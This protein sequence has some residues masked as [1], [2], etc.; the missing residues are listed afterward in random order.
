L[1]SNNFEEHHCLAQLELLLFP[2]LVGI[3]A[4]AD[5]ETAV[6]AEIAVADE[7]VVAVDTAAAE[8]AAVVDK[9]AVLDVVADDG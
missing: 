3:A 9:L 2:A 4:V 7:F 8:F 6:A 1:I 5:T